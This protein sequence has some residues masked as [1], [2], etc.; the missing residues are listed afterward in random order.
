MDVLFFI[1][2]FLI[3]S[4]LGSFLNVVVFRLFRK[5]SFWQGRSMCPQC[6]SQLKWRDLIPVL[7][8]ILLKARCRICRHKIAIQYLAVELATGSLFVLGAPF[9]S[10]IRTSIL[11]IVVVGFFVSL[12]IFD[13]REY[14]IPD[15][16]SI[17]AIILIGFGN[18]IFFDNWAAILLGGLFGGLWFLLQFV[19]SRGRWVGGGDIRLGALVGVLLGHPLLWLSLMIAYVGGSIIALALMALGR[20]KMG[21]RLPFAAFLLPAAFITW[22]WG[23]AIWTWYSGVIGF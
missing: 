23:A 21:D 11:Y 6:G 1:L 2:M 16:L 18:I 10:D 13:I 4:C 17:P 22:I 19:I 12:F 20:K 3:G 14:I 5:Q 9:F 15:K 7:S 8:Y